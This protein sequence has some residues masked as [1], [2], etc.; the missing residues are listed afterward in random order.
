M[1]DYG[2]LLSPVSTGESSTFR[3]PDSDVLT[4]FVPEDISV[5]LSAGR[6]IVAPINPATGRRELSMWSC[7]NYQ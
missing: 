4:V 7:E 2:I 3:T 5:Q 1:K 6:R